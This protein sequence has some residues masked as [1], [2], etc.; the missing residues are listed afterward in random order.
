VCTEIAIAVELQKSF[1]D[2]LDNLE[3]SEGRRKLKKRSDEEAGPVQRVY[4]VSG[5]LETL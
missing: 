5:Q 3:N 2:L 1:D 4:Q